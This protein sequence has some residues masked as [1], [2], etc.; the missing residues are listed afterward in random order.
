MPSPHPILLPDL[1]S[2]LS[3]PAIDA[4]FL[5]DLVYLSEASPSSS[6]SSTSSTVS[7]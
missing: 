5:L 6:G 1:V 2:S 4:S 7:S 3:D